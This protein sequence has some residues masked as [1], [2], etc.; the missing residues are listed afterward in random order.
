MTGSINRLEEGVLATLLALMTIL[1]FVQVVLRYA[2]NSGL[3]WSLEATTYLF[4]ALILFGMSYGVRTQTHIAVDLVIRR[5]PRR[6]AKIVNLVAIL[7]CLSYALLMLYG[8]AVFVDRLMILGNHAR[9][10]PLPK[11]LLTV[12]MPLGFTLLAFRFLEAGWRILRGER[13]TE[14]GS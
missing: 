3:V 9:D 14:T 4:A 5:L 10:I 2:F 12:T 11:W 13:E 1:T 7:A 6:A 8:S